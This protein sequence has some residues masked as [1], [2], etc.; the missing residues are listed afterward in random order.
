MTERQLTAAMR[1]RKVNPFK[2]MD[3]LERARQLESAGRS[4]VHLEVGEPDFTAHPLIVEAAVRAMRSG[5]T[6]YTPA[7][8]LPALRERIA[9]FYSQHHGVQVDVSRIIVTPGASGALVLLSNLLLNPSDQVMMPD[10]AYPCNRNYVHLMGAEAVLIAPET[11][12]LAA[13]TTA[14][15][16]AAYNESSKGLWLAS[17]ANPTGAVIDATRMS[18]LSDWTRQRGMHLVMDEIYHGLDFVK[19]VA[20]VT[21]MGDLPTALKFD[22]NN[23]VINSFS[24]YFGMTGWRVGW[25][26]VPQAFSEMAN[27]L[28]Q[29]LFIAAST[30]SQYAALHAFDDDV[31][32]VLEERRSEFRQRRDFLASALQ[33]IGFSLPWQ[34]QGAFYCYADIGAFADDCELFCQQML[35][36][37][38]VAM[39]PGTDFGQHQARRY[40]RLAY[41]RSMPD[42]ELAA[43]RIVDA[44]QSR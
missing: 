41:T 29:N 3:V 30:P 15:L 32:G 1:T 42:L 4:I 35:E 39:T 33:H 11:P 7:S 9:Q 26:V 24:K 13:P 25:V 36:Q 18:E 21:P 17:P 28:A 38:G 22:D 34:P 12:G 6:Q 37:H 10:P 23:F 20:D 16:D 27:I 43:Q 8:G 31:T 40:V 44:L 2:V 14:Q 5:K 19:P